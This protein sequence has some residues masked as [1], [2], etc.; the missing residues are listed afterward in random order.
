MPEVHI[1]VAVAAEQ[2]LVVPV[3]RN[4]DKKSVEEISAESARLV[5]LARRGAW[6]LTICREELSQ[7]QTWECLVY[8]N[9][10]PLLI[11]P[12]CYTG[13]RSH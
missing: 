12:G 3:V 7:F 4:V 10:R 8:L 6:A 9:L 5:D 2:G 13:R 11:P 1:G